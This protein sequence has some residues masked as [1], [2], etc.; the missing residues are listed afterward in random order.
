MVMNKK[1]GEKAKPCT[2][3]EEK[4]NVIPKPKLKQIRKGECSDKRRNCSKEE[5]K[6]KRI[7]L[8]LSGFTKERNENESG[9]GAKLHQIFR[10][11]EFDNIEISCC[12]R[13]G[14]Y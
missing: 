12:H 14:V 13:P 10:I 11:Q 9:C 6:M 1:K 3:K 2:Q 8:I 7:N 5:S 4:Y